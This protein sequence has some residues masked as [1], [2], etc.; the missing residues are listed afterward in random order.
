M[1]LLAGGTSEAIEIALALDRAKSPYII[2]VATGYGYDE[3]AGKVSGHVLKGPFDKQSFE[4]LIKEYEV[5]AVVDASHVYA[6]ELRC[7]LS[8]AAHAA[9]VRLVRFERDPVSVDSNPDITFFGSPAELGVWARDKDF[10]KIFVSTG[11]KGLQALA[12]HIDL[13][14][15]YA[16]MLPSGESITAALSAGLKPSHII[17]MEGPFSRDLNE[18]LFRHLRIDLLVTK[19]SGETGGF[20]AKIEAAGNTGCLVAVLKRPEPAGG[21]VFHDTK[22]LLRTLGIADEESGWHV[23]LL[24]HGSRLESANRGLK[25]VAKEMERRGQYLGVTPAFLQHAE[26][27]LD[28]V[29]QELAESG[30]GRIVIMPLF[31][32]EGVHIT[33]DIPEEIETIQARYPHMQVVQSRFI[34]PDPLLAGICIHRIK[35]TIQ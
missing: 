21:E 4:K 20:T 30:A 22:S 5:D 3:T 18:A 32:F 29:F 24:G 13:D 35:D 28:K 1:I 9:G 31:L 25:L 7:E 11:I 26:P 12:G 19:D 10:K 16:R 23:V 14:R 8:A 17:A 33:S 27:S 34:G 15:V 2:T 6:G